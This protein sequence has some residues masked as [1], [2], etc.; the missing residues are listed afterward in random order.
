[1]SDLDFFDACYKKEEPRSEAAFGIGDEERLAFTTLE[2]EKQVA[3]VENR[4]ERL[5]QFTP[6]D[7][8]IVIKINNDE[9]SMCD[10]M[11][12]IEETQGLI[13][14]ELKEG[15]R[16]WL[17]DAME[18]L[19]S[20]ISYFKANHE[21]SSFNKPMAYAINK[22]HPSFQSSKKDV[23]TA[24]RHETGFRLSTDRKIVIK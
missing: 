8:N 17:T 19:K 4:A 10:G 1:M 24:F 2:A 18:Q 9:V 12:T 11:L 3:L 16:S 15:A 5:I 21:L 14:V 6:V 23:M 7:H 20:T 13:F 22:Q